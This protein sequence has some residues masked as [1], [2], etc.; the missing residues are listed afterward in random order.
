[1][2]VL[3]MIFY[4]KILSKG[5][6]LFL[7]IFYSS[8][9]NATPRYTAS[10]KYTGFKMLTCRRSDNNCM[11]IKSPVAYVNEEGSAYAFDQAEFSFFKSGSKRRI[12]ISGR[13][14]Y[15]DQK[16]KMILIRHLLSSRHKQAFINLRTDHITYVD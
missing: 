8:L 13:D 4:R 3:K 6:I 11:Q 16:N 2:S 9:G 5:A 10:A 12:I 1:M 7:W 15:Y 14:I